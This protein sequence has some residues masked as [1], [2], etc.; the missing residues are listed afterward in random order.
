MP[1]PLI[2]TDLDGTLLMT[3]SQTLHPDAYDAVHQAVSAGIPLVFATGRSPVDVLPIA[4]LV[5][6]RWFAVC[7]DG[8]ALVDLR[9]NEVVSTHPMDVDDSRQIVRAI[10]SAYPD[11]RFMID[12]VQPGVI[13]PDVHGL[14]IEEGFKAP[15]ADTKFGAERIS[16]IED[17]LDDPHIV[18]ICMYIPSDSDQ[19]DIF[20][21]AHSLVSPYSTVVRI[22]SEDVFVDLCKR[23]VSKASGVAEVAALSGIH[24]EDVFAVGDLHNDSEMLGWAGFSFAVANAHPAIQDIADVVVPSNDEGGVAQ[25]VAAAMEHL[26]QP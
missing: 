5:G 4:E 1:L 15:W 25:V 18:K 12:R 3:G 22:H 14:I 9:N 11:A 19:D 17:F 16:N 7:C 21:N 24:V 2:A 8:T 6:H 13:E 20:H 10:R 26:L 23:G